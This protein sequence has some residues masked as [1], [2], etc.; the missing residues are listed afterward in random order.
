MPRD[1]EPREREERGEREEEG[2]P[3]EIK[4]LDSEEVQAA[5][6]FLRNLIEGMD[7]DAEVSIR[8]PETAADGA[9]RA[10]AVLDIE[11]EDL[12][13]LIGRRGTT[14]AAL[15]YMVNVMLT[16]KMDSRV[17]VT[18]DVEHYHRRREETL[19]NL[20]RRMADRVRQ[21]RRPITLEPMPAGERRIIHI[22]LADNPSVI[23]ASTGFGEGRKIVIKPRGGNGRPPGRGPGMRPGGQRFQGPRI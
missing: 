17:L 4:D 11:G 3:V 8:E 18:V 2:E 19:Q 13:L 22:A 6:E 5:A 16:R 12:G 7:I 14:L 1:E 21:S 10:S 9:G 23:T 20:A 15:Q